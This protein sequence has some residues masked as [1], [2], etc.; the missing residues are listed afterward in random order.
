MGLREHRVYHRS[1]SP[2]FDQLYVDYGGEILLSASVRPALFVE[3]LPLAILKIRLQYEL[4]AWSGLHLGLGHG[5]TFE[6]KDA[7]F[8]PDTLE[9]REGEERANVGHRAFVMPTLQ[10]R[11][12]RIVLVDNLELAAWFVHGGAA[13]EYWYDSIDDNLVKKGGLDGTLKNQL[14]VGA[15]LW[16]G[17]G[18][19]QLVAGVVHEYLRT[20]SAGIS[21]QRLAMCVSYTLADALWGLRR[22]AILLLGGIYLRDR[23]RE[24]ELFIQL[25]L[26]VDYEFD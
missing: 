6:G 26:K 12:W 7:P 17:S 22:P 2:L 9:A 20:F 13:G 25:G 24:D 1:E 10:L 19:A 8:D 3:W 21:R 11:L 16:D 15:V 14:I 23:N 18:D 4:W 5:L